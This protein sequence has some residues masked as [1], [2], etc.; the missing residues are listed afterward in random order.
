MITRYLDGTPVPEHM[1]N[2]KFVP[3]P[4]PKMPSL[5]FTPVRDVNVP[6]TWGKPVPKPK[7][8]RA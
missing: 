8:K 1:R 3:W 7:G 6:A 2:L 5:R 4:L